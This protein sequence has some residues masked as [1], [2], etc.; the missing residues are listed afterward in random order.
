MA[1]ASAQPAAG[2]Y[3]GLRSCRV[4][5][6]R[7]GG[8][9]PAPHEDERPRALGH[10]LADRHRRVVGQQDVGAPEEPGLRLLRPTQ[11]HADRSA[12][13]PA[14]LTGGRWT[15]SAPYPPI[16]RVTG[17]SPDMPSA[18]AAAGVRSITRP[19]T[20]GPRSLMVTTTERP[21]LRLVTRTLVPN[22]RLLCA[23]VYALALAYSPLAV[24]PPLY[25][26][27]I[28]LWV[29]AKSGVEITIDENI[30]AVAH[31][32]LQTF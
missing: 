16:L 30:A 18:R 10:D 27:A 32:F 9:L 28:P 4:R 2:R 14:R 22:G 1:L 24:F 25:T 17:A 7:E 21:L 3:A 12:A 15:T 13:G 6:H 5:A 26:E 19:R 20:K 8:R 11:L 29:A 31:R 23:A